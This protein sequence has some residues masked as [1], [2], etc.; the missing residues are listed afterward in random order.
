MIKGQKKSHSFAETVI[1]TLVG[2]GLSLAAQLVIFPYFD[3]HTTF[4]ENFHIALL[5]TIISIIR[6]Y[7]MR[8]VFNF[9]HIK[10][11]L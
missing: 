6:G 2:L 9:I 4:T 7:V 1:N 3:I 8:R 10:G 11:W 5:F